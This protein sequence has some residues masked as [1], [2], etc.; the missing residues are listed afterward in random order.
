MEPLV[1]GDYPKS[2]KDLVKERLPVFTEEEK[3]LVKGSFD[4]IGIN[5]Y[6]SRYAKNMKPKSDGP[7]RY[8]TDCMADVTR[9]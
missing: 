7:P 9:T 6:T 2:M 3:N 4:F 1:F 5:Y 8:T